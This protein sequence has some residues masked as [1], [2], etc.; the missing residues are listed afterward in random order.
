MGIP[1]PRDIADGRSLRNKSVAEKL[2]NTLQFY[3]DPIKGTP[4]SKLNSHWPPS[5]KEI[6]DYQMA[7]IE[8]RMP[9][10]PKMQK[11]AN[12][13]TNDI[14]VPFEEGSVPLEEALSS[15]EQALS[16]QESGSAAQLSKYVSTD[17]VIKLMGLYETLKMR[18]TKVYNLINS[19]GAAIP[20]TQ[21]KAELDRISSMITI[22]STEL[23]AMGNSSGAYTVSPDTVGYLKTAEWLGRRLKGKYLEVVG[24]EWIQEKVPSNIKVVNVGKVTG[25]VIDILGQVSGGGKMIRTDIMGFD[26]SKNV[27]ISF[28]TGK[29]RTPRTM[30]LQDFLNFIE[31]EGETT[32]INL[33]TD[34]FQQLQQALVLGIQAKAGKN[35]AIFNPKGVSLNQAIATEGVS[36][37]YANNLQ[38]LT[39]LVQDAKWIAKTHDYYDAMFNWCLAKGLTNIIGKENNLVL[40]RNG[41]F[42]M[43]DYLINQWKQGKKCI[44]AKG[45]VHIDKP[46]AM[47]QVAYTS[48]GSLGE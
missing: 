3:D 2:N 28:T 12:N 11:L 30:K 13:L 20:G 27:E 38:L 42:L 8:Q 41:I 23:N 43:R 1:T 19:T 47:V 29:E 45:R 35:Q 44:Q 5:F 21:L 6:G 26:L 15:I 34:G 40:T 36:S 33:D 37:H 18:L 7:M 25:P 22:I 17:D 16:F 48:K 31:K 9:I 14:N 32:T 46:D 4:Y 24:T 39:Q 10:D